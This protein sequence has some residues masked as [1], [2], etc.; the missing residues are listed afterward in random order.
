M[1][2]TFPFTQTELY[3]STGVPHYEAS[4]VIQEESAFWLDENEQGHKRLLLVTPAEH[5]RASH[6]EGE[7]L[8]LRSNYI[9]KN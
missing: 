4:F 8:A 1:S 2:E 7:T 5:P 6:F 9:L 3:A